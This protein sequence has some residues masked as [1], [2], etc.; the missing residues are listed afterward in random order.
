MQQPTKTQVDRTI[1]DLANE[2]IV[3]LALAT[4]GGATK[5]IH[6]EEIAEQALALAPEKFSWRL[7]K[8]RNLGWPQIF[9]V[10]N[11]LE[12]AQKPMKGAY[13]RG[14]CTTNLAKDGWS[15]TP[16]GAA[17]VKEQE[18]PLESR[19]TGERIVPKPDRDRFRRRLDAV[20]KSEAYRQFV[21]DGSLENVNVY[22]FAE[23]L[24]SNPAAS[25]NVF[26]QKFNVLASQAIL[27]DDQEISR[28]FEACA[29]KFGH[30]MED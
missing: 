27:I 19:R 13:V 5:R 21:K 3:T 6:T 23:L 25:K 15:L 4:L 10:K 30:M 8:Y 11:A 17:W 14:Q 9:V 12:D 20:R 24:N 22:A 28:F 1:A 7:K 18:D 2:L 26:Q 16:A 29:Q